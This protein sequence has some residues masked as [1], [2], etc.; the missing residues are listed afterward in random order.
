M[1]LLAITMANNCRRDKLGASTS[2]EVA[3]AACASNHT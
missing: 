3:V 1:V 2:T